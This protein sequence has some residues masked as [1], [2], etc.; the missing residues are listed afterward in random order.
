MQ[1]SALFI[2]RNCV[3]RQPVRILI[4]GADD[5]AHDAASRLQRLSFAPCQVAAYVRLPGQEVAISDTPIYD[6]EDL[7]KIHLGNG[8]N[9]AVIAVHPASFHS[10]SIIKQLKVQVSPR[11]LSLTSARGS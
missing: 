5:S 3:L 11:G 1:R 6:L 2:V 8:V 7:D 4:V 9:E 10:S